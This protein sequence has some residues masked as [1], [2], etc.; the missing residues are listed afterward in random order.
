M[1]QNDQRRAKIPHLEDDSSRSNGYVSD[2]EISQDENSQS[3]GQTSSSEGRP[4]SVVWEFFIR[5]D[6]L[7]C[8][9]VRCKSRLK[10]SGSSTSSMMK[11]IKSKH[12][13]ELLALCKEKNLP[14]LHGETS[15]PLDVQRIEGIHKAIDKMFVLDYVPFNVVNRKGFRGVCK[16]LDPN[17]ELL[18]SNTYRDRRLPKN[19]QNA[20]EKIRRE[21]MQDLP[22]NS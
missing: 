22:G 1:S 18:S 2:D 4:K 19:Y 5:I 15:T 7:F 17:F 6:P 12:K 8:E 11:H 9:C 21:I 3:E 13:E 20:K 10:M 16:A 14:S